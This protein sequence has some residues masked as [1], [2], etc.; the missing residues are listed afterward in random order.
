M[1]NESFNLN[2]IITN[3]IDDVTTNLVSSKKS[4]LQR[5][6]IK[7]LYTPTDIFI[8][9]DKARVTQV[10]S[11]L[12][13]NAVKFTEAKANEGSDDGDKGEVGGGIISI[14]IEKVDGQALV[15]VKDSGIGIDPEIMPRLFEKFIS[16]SYQGTGLGLFISKSIIQAH[17]G[18]IWAKNNPDGKGATVT[19]SLPISK[20]QNNCRQPSLSE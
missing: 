16:K 12:L 4:H 19:F 13:I 7:L 11:N 3:I 8:Q 1:K 15:S 20:Q 18:K 9:A 2:D 10:I 17:G 5:N 6:V 14:N